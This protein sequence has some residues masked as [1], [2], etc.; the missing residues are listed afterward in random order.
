MKPIKVIKDPE[1]FKLVA[2]ETRRKIVF[3][4]RVK[5][6]TVSQIA[7]EL[8]I[9]PQAVYHHIKKLK[10]GDL[11]EVSREVRIDHLIESY[12]RATAE[13]FHFSVGKVSPSVRTQLETVLNAL[14]KLG[15]N[16]EYDEE[17]IKQL[18]DIRRRVESCCGS[19]KFENAIS[20][21]DDVDFVTKL[22][23]QEYAE[24]LSMSDKEFIEQQELE[25]EFR[26]VI[27]SLLKE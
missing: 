10:K 5:E 7:A 12:Y 26:K 21:L 8:N 2:D 25:N 16:L 19:G 17:K 20:E 23:V 22:V 18:S 3:L 6:M 4:L 9:T 24:I 1:A 11:I 15:F 27:F 13:A 14:K